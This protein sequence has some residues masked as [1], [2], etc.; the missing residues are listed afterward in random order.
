MSPGHIFDKFAVEDSK[1]GRFGGYAVGAIVSQVARKLLG[2]EPHCFGISFA[3]L[4]Y[5]CPLN[6]TYVF[7]I[8]AWL[9][10]G[11]S[12]VGRHS[13]CGTSYASTCSLDIFGVEE[14]IEEILVLL[15]CRRAWS[16]LN[17][18]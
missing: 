11:S 15:D 12:C 5:S 6:V 10:P 16:C 4:L 17:C 2:G 13:V 3:V 7:I 8:D 1:G 14:I 9:G 18:L